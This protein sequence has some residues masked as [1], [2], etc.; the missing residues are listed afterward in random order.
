[1]DVFQAPPH[2]LDFA[3]YIIKPNCDLIDFSIN[4]SN[5]CIECSVGNKA[6]K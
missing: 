3:G 4:A 5:S 1:M 2:T 6:K